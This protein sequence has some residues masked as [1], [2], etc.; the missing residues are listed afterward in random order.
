MLKSPIVTADK[1]QTV[2]NAL[3]NGRISDLTAKFNTL[4]IKKGRES[5]MPEV[6][7][8]FIDQYKAHKKDPCR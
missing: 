6:I 4:L 7:D 3:T 5:N 2:L 8:G 1:K